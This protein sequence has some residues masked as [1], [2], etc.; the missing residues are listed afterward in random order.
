[1]IARENARSIA[2]RYIDIVHRAG[3]GDAL[4]ANAR[5]ST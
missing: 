3:I 1:M 5:R 4:C 2:R